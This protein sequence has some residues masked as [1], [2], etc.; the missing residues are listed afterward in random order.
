MVMIGLLTKN[1]TNNYTMTEEEINNVISELVE[2]NNTLKK[3]LTR[4]FNHIDRPSN[5]VR[6]PQ[7]NVAVTDVVDGEFRWTEGS[8]EDRFRDYLVAVENKIGKT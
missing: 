1:Q 2:E 7:L 6:W 8:I 3:L 4:L 5:T